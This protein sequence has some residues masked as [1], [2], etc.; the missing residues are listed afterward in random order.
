MNLGNLTLNVARF[1][2][3]DGKLGISINLRIPVH[4]STSNI[5]KVFNDLI[6]NTCILLFFDGEKDA[7]YIPKENKLVA[8]LCN[9]F[10]EVTK[11]NKSPI[12]IGGATYARAFSN[13]VSF[14][15]N[16][17]GDEDMCHK[18]DE[19]ISINNLILSTKIYATSIYK[20]CC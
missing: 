1:Y 13:F 17:P 11:Q 12:A 8:S 16:M 2:L 6:Q 7:L 18:I 20:L 3:E 9:I 5:K 14:G 10:N 4:T 19:F 15:A